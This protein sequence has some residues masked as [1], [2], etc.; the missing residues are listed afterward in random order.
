MG[1]RERLLDLAGGVPAGRKVHG[2]E[3]REQLDLRAVSR[4]RVAG[5]LHDLGPAL[6]L[7]RCF[8]VGRPLE[9]PVTRTTVI[10][11][12]GER[13]A[14]GLEVLCEDLRL[15][16]LHLGEPLPQH[17]GDPQVEILARRSDQRLVG[18]VAHEDVP[19]EV[20]LR[21]RAPAMKDQPARAQLDEILAQ[22]RLVAAGDC[23]DHLVA[24]LPAQHGG[25]LGGLPGARREPVE[26]GGQEV[27]ET[28]RNGERA[29]P[30]ASARARARRGDCRLDERAGDLL[31]EERD[32]VGAA[33]DLVQHGVRQRAS[34]CEG[35][36]DHRRDFARV[37]TGELDRRHVVTRPRGIELLTSGEQHAKASRRRCAGHRSGTELLDQSGDH[38]ER[39]R[40]RP[41]DVLDHH[42]QRAC[43]RGP[44]QQRQ[45]GVQRQLLLPFRGQ[46]QTWVPLVRRPGQER[47]EE[48]YGRRKVEAAAGQQRSRP[49]RSIRPRAGCRRWSPSLRQ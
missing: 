16:G 10:L 30:G 35:V 21:P 6:E 8:D 11:A 3:R 42:D 1:T 32:P 4:R 27:A 49:G 7:R 25:E 47:V 38:L 36:G 5:G 17:V 33:D 48:R 15:H 20:A 44:Q 22:T 41:L 26:A 12:G 2:P 29:C 31:D 9:S 14:P 24:E 43:F 23:A 19:E 46:N 13:L 37:E 39:R 34:V 28:R 18:C 45:E 40:I